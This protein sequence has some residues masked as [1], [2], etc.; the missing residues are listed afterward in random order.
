[1]SRQSSPVC[2]FYFLYSERKWVLLL[3][4]TLKPQERKMMSDR[5]RQ[6]ATLLA[7]LT[8]GFVL[9]GGL[10]F[11]A[12]NGYLN[13]VLGTNTTNSTTTTATTGLVTT[14]TT[15]GGTGFIS[16]TTTSG[17][18]GGTFS[19]PAAGPSGDQEIVTLTYCAVLDCTFDGCP[20]YPTGVFNI[21]GGQVCDVLYLL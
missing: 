5:A 1:M 16:T 4:L 9:G 10:M 20:N 6:G 17:S 12:S 13:F 14:G 18:T 11:G 8:F 2:L 7:T 19:F 21:A 15:G 3:T